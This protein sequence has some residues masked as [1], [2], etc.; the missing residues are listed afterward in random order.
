MIEFVVDTGAVLNTILAHGGTLKGRDP[1]YRVQGLLQYYWGLLCP[2]PQDNINIR[3]LVRDP[4]NPF[5]RHTRFLVVYLYHLCITTLFKARECIIFEFPDSIPSEDEILNIVRREC[6]IPA[7]LS[8][9][10]THVRQTFVGGIATKETCA[11]WSANESGID[12]PQDVII[13]LSFLRDE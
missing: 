5:Y 1:F 12:D 9:V 3:A 7:N 6:V 4:T 13:S 10:V 11:E 8:D 2:A